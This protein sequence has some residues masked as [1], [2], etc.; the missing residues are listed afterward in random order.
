MTGN[1][2]RAA[3]ADHPHLVRLPDRLQ[4]EAERPRIRLFLTDARDRLGYPSGG[5]GAG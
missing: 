5:R 1:V 2:G 3:I 4:R